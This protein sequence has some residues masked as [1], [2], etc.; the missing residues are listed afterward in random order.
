LG[1]AVDLVF[2]ETDKLHRTAVPRNS[3]Y[4]ILWSKFLPHRHRETVLS[5]IERS[6][7]LEFF[8]GLDELAERIRTLL[9]GKT[10]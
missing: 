1:R 4:V 5:I 2:I 10:A 6:R 3:D 8:G 9:F 7:V